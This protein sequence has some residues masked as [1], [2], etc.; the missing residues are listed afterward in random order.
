MRE[1]NIVS[2]HICA[3]A[4]DAERAISDTALRADFLRLLIDLHEFGRQARDR[5][6]LPLTVAH[7]GPAPDSGE[8][9]PRAAD[10]R[11]LNAVADNASDAVADDASRAFFARLDQADQDR[12]PMLSNRGQR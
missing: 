8:G 12:G 3:M 9:A 1:F 7:A 5:G 11:R 4:R 10:G 6:L 2:G